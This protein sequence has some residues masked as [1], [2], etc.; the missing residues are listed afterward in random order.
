[1][2][3]LA[4][5][6]LLTSTPF[7]LEGEAC[8][9]HEVL[10]REGRALGLLLVA[11][12]PLVV[13]FE[14]RASAEY[15]LHVVREGV[16]VLTRTLRGSCDEAGAAAVV[17]IERLVRDLASRPEPPRE[18]T[19]GATPLVPSEGRV[20]AP[21]Q[22]LPDA[23]A[24]SSTAPQRVLPAGPNA[25]TRKSPRVLAADPNASSSVSGQ[26]VSPE[27]PNAST[28]KTP[29]RVLPTE[30]N[31]PAGKTPQGTP[32]AEVNGSS[33]VTPQGGLPA[34]PNPSASQRAP[35]S[36]TPPRGF[37]TE[38]S[39]PT[40]P[41]AELSRADTKPTPPL[42]LEEWQLEAGG[43]VLGPTTG[44]V[45]PLLALDGSAR[46]GERWRLG[47]RALFSF[48][49]EVP[50]TDQAANVRRGTLGTRDVWVLL[51]P[52]VCADGGRA[53]VCAGPSAGL[54]AVIGQASGPYV[55]QTAVRVSPAFTTGATVDLTLA[56]GRFRAVLG[57][58]VLVT[59]S[60][61]VI[62]LEGLTTTTQGPVIEGLGT[63][64][65]GL[66]WPRDL[67]P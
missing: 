60:P 58:S 10:E 55:F 44:V 61:P 1:M 48:G 9:P 12:A 19:S 51:A 16:E 22:A 20:A 14:R 27:G 31:A 38:P 7:S 41:L 56:V 2:S 11:H 25:S 8:A 40:T 30:P 59:P 39:A 62:S 36:V 15:E 3:W 26:R 32:P 37:S 23:N 54:R 63:L 28:N 29:E 13:R 67:N 21:G 47:G 45:S 57:A 53:R 65:V 17:V 50:I 4:L 52:A 35:S 6:V 42:E 5:S 49:S 46:F 33:S 64:T 34:E 66:A 18:A 24:S 43:G